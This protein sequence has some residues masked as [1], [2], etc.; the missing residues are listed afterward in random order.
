MDRKILKYIIILLIIITIITIILLMMLTSKNKEEIYIATKP[1]EPAILEKRENIYFIENENLYFS[2][3]DIMQKYVDS[4]ANKE[5]DITYDMLNTNYIEENNI[6]M[7]N[8]TN[9]LN[10]YDMPKFITIHMCTKEADI[11]NNIYIEAIVQDYDIGNDDTVTSTQNE[12]YFLVIVDDENETFAIDPID[13]DE[14]Q[15]YMNNV[16]SVEKTS[17]QENDNNIISYNNIS[18]EEIVTQHLNHYLSLLR[19]NIQKAYELLEEEYKEARYKNYSEFEKYAQGIE[20][21]RIYLESYTKKYNDD[22]SIEYICKDG[23]DRVYI[24]KEKTVMEYT[25]QLDDYTLENEEFREKYTKETNKNRGVLN[26]DK[27]FKMLNMQD[28]TLAYNLLDDNFKQN[29]FNTQADFEN[30]IKQRTFKYNKVTY[31]KYSNK[32]DS[33]HIYEITLTDRTEE[34][35]ESYDYTFI[36]KLGDDINFTVSFE[37]N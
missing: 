31:N 2:I 14:Y 23:Y 13:E 32:I 35:E 33:V 24:F 6:N 25:V 16:K 21:E 36:I 15:D 12:E 29:Y 3:Q 27:F 7:D 28:Y 10:N 34:S 26:I 1:E 19:C 9:K 22:D 30:Y 11:G 8:I 5:Y 4:I 18:E 20:D 17:I 37:V